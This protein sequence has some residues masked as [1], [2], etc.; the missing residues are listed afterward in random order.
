M[1]KQRIYV[2]TSVL[3]GCFDPEFEVWSNGLINDFRKG[4]FRLVLSDVTTAEIERAPEPV[5]DLHEELVSIAEL[6]PVTEEAIDLLSAYE[7]HGIL[8]TRFRNDMLHIAIA[9]VVVQRPS[10]PCAVWVIFVVF[11]NSSLAL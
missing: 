10:L 8:S 3:G 7:G 9:T 11:T 4:E 5:R 1:R 6:L 2:D